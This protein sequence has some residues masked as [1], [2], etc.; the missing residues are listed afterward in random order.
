MRSPGRMVGGCAL[1]TIRIPGRV[2]LH[3]VVVVDAAWRT[4]APGGSVR[5]YHR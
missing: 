5:R 4:A 1:L 3:P 2:L